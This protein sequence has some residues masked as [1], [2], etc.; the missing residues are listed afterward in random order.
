MAIAHVA[1]GGFIAGTQTATVSVTISAGETVIVGAVGVSDFGTSDF[2]AAGG[3]SDSGVGNYARHVIST[4]AWKAAIFSYHNHP[5]GTVTITVD[6]GGGAF[7]PRTWGAY[8]RVTGLLTASSFDVAASGQAS[9]GART[10]GNLSGTTAQN[11]EYE[12][13][14]VV[15][16]AASGITVDSFTPA[17]TQIVERNTGSDTDGEADYRILTGTTNA[18]CSWTGGS[19][20]YAA[21]AATFKGDTG[22]GGGGTTYSGCDGTGCFHHDPK[23]FAAREFARQREAF[24]RRAVRETMRRA[25]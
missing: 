25:A 10:T 6:Q 14:V 8:A 17:Y 15:S 11:D 9:S 12:F 1:G 24:L 18:G 2:A 20:D 4:S 13:A 21:A 5:G 23:L 7:N 16:N 22:G 3:C 19:L